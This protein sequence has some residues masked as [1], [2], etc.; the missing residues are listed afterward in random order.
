MDKSGASCC[1]FRL[2]L[3]TNA[4][5]EQ[6]QSILK[7]KRYSQVIEIDISAGG[8]GEV[9]GTTAKLEASRHLATLKFSMSGES[10][11]KPFVFKTLT[12]GSIAG[13]N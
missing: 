2:D 9:K 4:P 3:L 12:V 8:Q 1:S 7:Y 5:F 13:R 6:Y 10:T 11:R